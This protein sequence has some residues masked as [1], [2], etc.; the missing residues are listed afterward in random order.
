MTRK[1]RLDIPTLQ[2]RLSAAEYR[3]KQAEEIW[4]T[5]VDKIRTNPNQMNIRGLWQAEQLQTLVNVHIRVNERD[6]EVA[7][8]QN[9]IALSKNAKKL[10]RRRAYRT[11]NAW[12]KKSKSS[13]TKASSA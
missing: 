4:N 8:L 6:R 7:E 12:T 5:L 3:L 9:L 2:F 13:T 11:V 1:R 10:P